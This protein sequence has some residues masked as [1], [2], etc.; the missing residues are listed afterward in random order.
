MSI[1]GCS[2]T[3][4][5]ING[6]TAVTLANS[7]ISVTVLPQKGADIYSFVDNAS[8][9]DVLAKTPWGLQPPGAPAR[10]GSGTFEFLHNY[11][12]AWQELLPNTLFPSTYEG[13]SIPMH[14]EVAT[15]PWDLCV[16]RDDLDEVRICLKVKCR[17][18]PL[19]L[20]RRMSLSRS[21]PVLT[22]DETVYNFSDRKV[23]FAWG[24]HPLLGAP[25]I[26]AG[27]RIDVG[28]ATVHVKQPAEPATATLAADQRTTWPYAMRIDGSR[29]DLRDI[30]GPDANTHDHAY[31]TEFEQ[32]WVQIE[33]PRLA[34]TFRLEWDPT[35]FRWLINWRPL[36]GSHT[37]PLEDVYGIAIE[38]W[39]TD[40]NLDAAIQGGD[41]LSLEGW[42]TL[43]TSL[44]AAL[45]GT[46][47]VP[48]TPSRAL[49]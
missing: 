35:V 2:I 34:L 12:G 1:R 5:E 47:N 31:L 19:A 37:A 3:L 10:A 15:L 9:I 18:I 39:S 27:C 6:W 42:C 7:A 40:W 14:G 21:A 43:S 13:R 49:K 30:P 24:H 22:I 45:Y 20:T 33:N 25:F 11:E 44:K 29:A 16:E 36:G 41:A 8:G 23:L 4:T 46:R 28:K 26:E 17:Q 38:P 32:G 48:T